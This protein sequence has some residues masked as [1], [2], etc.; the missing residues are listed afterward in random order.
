VETV[1]FAR[2]RLHEQVGAGGMG[3]V[4]RSTDQLLQQ[5]VALKRI[6]LAAL[7]ADQAQ[8][9]RDRALREARL[10]AQL[11][12][13]PHVVS[14]YDVLID[15]ND[16]WLVMEYLPACSLT[17]IVKTDG[18]LDP[19]EVARIGAAIADALASGHSLGIEH[20][21][22]TP[23][24]VLIGTGDTVK[25]TDYG[26][27]H[28]AGDP[29]LTQ[30][31]I[32]GTPAYMAPEVASRGESSPASDIFS[33]G[34]TLYFAL[35]GQPPFGTDDNTHKMLNIVGTGII[36]QPTRAGPLEPL[37][38][39][40]LTLDP[41]TRPD[42]VTAGEMLAKLATRDERHAPLEP[43]PPPRRQRWFRTHQ[44]TAI[45]A[46]VL[47]TVAIAVFLILTRGA[48]PNAG[49]SP[50]PGAAG[51][52]D[53]PPGRL[54]RPTTS[55]DGGG[56]LAPAE[57]AQVE[58]SSPPADASISPHRDVAVAGTVT[59]PAGNQLWILAYHGDGGSYFMVPGPEGVS[60]V[61]T[62]DGPWEVTDANVGTASD[63]G[64]IIVYTAVQAD[65]ACAKWLSAKHDDDSFYPKELPAGCTIFPDNR[66]VLVK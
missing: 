28:L 29:R 58:F 30:A 13:Q 10:A 24:N 23:G 14:V 11:R 9:A 65:T 37:L 56:G 33:L 35:E 34:S 8:L 6:P 40:F 42:A 12:G 7:G 22:V 43:P 5:T 17:D 31:G 49:T 21:D 2:Y 48:S 47:L 50:L 52:T 55:G 59:Q 18:P 46:G 19:G 53:V 15:D 54:P 3:V 57:G 38:L 41:A 4:W 25:L 27:S 62:K 20:R 44:R 51:S 26:I 66:T 32:T 64:N 45:T 1:V 60:P 63:K 16:I 61:T 39:R 36:R